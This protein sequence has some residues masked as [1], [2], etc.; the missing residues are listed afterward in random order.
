M[1]DNSLSTDRKHYRILIIFTRRLSYLLP[2]NI[3][4]HSNFTQYIIY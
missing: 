1:I 2:R 3:F 4:Q